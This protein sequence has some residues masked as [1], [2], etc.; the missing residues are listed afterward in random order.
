MKTLFL[1]IAL[2]ISGCSGKIEKVEDKNITIEQNLTVEEKAFQDS[3]DKKI[4]ITRSFIEDSIL[5]TQNIIN[6]ILEKICL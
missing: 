1:I 6:Q 4:I 3:I 5:Y 2:F